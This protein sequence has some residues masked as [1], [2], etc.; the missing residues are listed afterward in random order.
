MALRILLSN[1]DGVNAPGLKAAAK[2]LR[3][4]GDLVIVAPMSDQSGV[5][6]SLTITRPLRIKKH[7]SKIYAVDGTP[8][9]CM[10]LAFHE[11]L[12]RDPQ[13]V[14]SGINHGPNMG[15]DVHYSGTVAAAIEG[16]IMGIP[17]IA[18]SMT[19]PDTNGRAFR[20]AA[21][22][23]R[24]LVPKIIGRI[25]RGTLLN[26]NFPAFPNGG[27]RKYQITRLGHRT[28]TDIISAKRDPRGRE[29]FWIGGEPTWARYKDTDAAAVAKGIV[30]ISP[31]NIDMTDVDLLNEMQEWKLR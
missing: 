22:F 3:T 14:V 21:K 18:V 24:R 17:S 2:E 25:P 13:V 29:Y 5:S 8:T 11:I 12:K 31:M 20:S 1:D 23:L 4:I 6:H 16:T 19:A 15:E 7:D 9:D 30:S 27:Y 10:T 26:I 28:Y